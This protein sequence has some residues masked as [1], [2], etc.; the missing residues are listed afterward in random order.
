[1]A[2]A[3]SQPA[4]NVVKGPAGN[5]YIDDGGSGDIP[6]IFAHSFGGSTQ[7]WNAQL[8]HLR[9]SRSAIAYDLRGHG[10]S[11]SP[12]NNDYDVMS[13]LKD[14]EAVVDHLHWTGLCWLATARVVR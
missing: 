14:L 8:E 1:M 11:A 13:Q 7:Q 6:V 4:A 9:R 5:I 10:R 2:T 3:T 12:A